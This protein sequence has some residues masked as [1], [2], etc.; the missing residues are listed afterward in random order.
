VIS[1]QSINRWSE[2]RSLSPLDFHFST[3]NCSSRPTWPVS[4]SSSTVLSALFKYSASPHSAHAVYRILSLNVSSS[5]VSIALGTCNYIGLVSYSQFSTNLLFS[6]FARKGV[7]TPGIQSA[8][9]CLVLRAS[10]PN[11]PGD[12]H[13]MSHVIV[14]GM[15]TWLSID[16]H[17]SRLC[18]IY[19]KGINTS[20]GLN[21]SL[22]LPANPVSKS[23]QTLTFKG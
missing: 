2:R 3:G 9:A 4:P 22:H 13:V 17:R 15:S 8:A 12:G 16:I 18:T 19:R 11:C 14:L 23:Y 20:N 6:C 21:V 7:Y 10:C 5:I 1:R